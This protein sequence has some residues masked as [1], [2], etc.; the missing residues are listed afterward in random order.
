MF[1]KVTAMSPL[2]N[3]PPITIFLGSCLLLS[4]RVRFTSLNQQYAWRTPSQ[5]SMVTWVPQICVS[6]LSRYCMVD[7]QR[8]SIL[9]LGCE[10]VTPRN[11]VKPRLMAP[12]PVSDSVLL[13]WNQEFTFLASCWWA[14]ELLVLG[15]HWKP[16]VSSPT[17][18]QAPAWP[19]LR[20][21]IVSS[22]WEVRLLYT[23]AIM[24]MSV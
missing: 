15:P 21:Q 18:G 7:W 19:E 12:P 24:E 20:S 17:T 2:P 3:T 5:D 6:L 9:M 14:L 11:L 4:S 8:L 10:S 13:G 22:L 16:L 1:S 23:S